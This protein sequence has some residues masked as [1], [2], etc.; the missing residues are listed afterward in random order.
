LCK[1]GSRCP[2][3]KKEKEDLIRVDIEFLPEQYIIKKYIRDRFNKQP[4]SVMYFCGECAE[5]LWEY[6]ENNKK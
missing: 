1:N 2:F 6:Y 5:R 3:Y 4:A